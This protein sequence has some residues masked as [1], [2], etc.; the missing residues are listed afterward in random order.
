MGTFTSELARNRSPSYE[1]DN[2]Y[3]GE[4]TIPRV[5]LSPTGNAALWA[6]HAEVTSRKSCDKIGRCEVLLKNNVNAK[7]ALAFPVRID[8]FGAVACDG[9]HISL[10]DYGSFSDTAYYVFLLHF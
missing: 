10:K 1:S 6:A 3:L 9:Q 5:G 4:Q 7:N 8:L 2:N